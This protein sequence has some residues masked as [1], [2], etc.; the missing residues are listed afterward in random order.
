MSERLPASAAG[1]AR[2]R[3]SLR[4]PNIPSRPYRAEPI[5]RR[6]HT[7]SNAAETTGCG[8]A[9]TVLKSSG[10]VQ[11]AGS[12]PQV[13]LWESRGTGPILSLC[14]STANLIPSFISYFI[15]FSVDGRDRMKRSERCA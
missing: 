11:N 12:E 5:P 8:P 15:W 4:N 2:L 14:A 13:P 3:H 9:I 1:R 6:M 7:N 10:N